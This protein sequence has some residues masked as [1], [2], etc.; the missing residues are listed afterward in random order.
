MTST[1]VFSLYIFCYCMT[2]LLIRR[3]LLPQVRNTVFTAIIALILMILG[4]IVPVF[5]AFMF[6]AGHW[7]LD[8]SGYWSMG[9]PFFVLDNNSSYRS[10]CLALTIVWA[11]IVSVLNLRWMIK[12]CLEFTPSPAAAPKSPEQP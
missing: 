6:D 3:V 9:N 1:F 7:S 12:R 4:C 2:A 10:R 8:D 11:L 5:L